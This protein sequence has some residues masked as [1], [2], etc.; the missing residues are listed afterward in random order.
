MFSSL[1]ILLSFAF[2][3]SPPAKFAIKYFTKRSIGSRVKDYAELLS[4]F[5]TCMSVT[6]FF[7]TPNLDFLWIGW[8]CG[9]GR[10]VGL[11]CTRESIK[12]RF[13][14]KKMVMYSWRRLDGG[15]HLRGESAFPRAATTDPRPSSLTAVSENS[16]FH[17]FITVTD[18]NREG[19][20]SAR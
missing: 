19:N 2:E 7:F 13:R 18:I 11:A 15:P 12:R 5:K 17:E 10:T 14:G 4:V 16:A 20:R 1:Y 9:S 3:Y 6:F 8:Y